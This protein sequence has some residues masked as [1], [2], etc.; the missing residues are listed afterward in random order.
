MTLTTSCIVLLNIIPCIIT[1]HDYRLLHRSLLDI[2]HD[3]YITEIY[4]AIKYV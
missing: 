4:N 1:Y 2:I 3:H